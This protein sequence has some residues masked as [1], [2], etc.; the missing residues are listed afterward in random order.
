MSPGISGKETLIIEAP[1]SP[2]KTHPYRMK[3][4]I[5]LVNQK[6]GGTPPFNNFDFQCIKKVY[7]IRRCF[8]YTIKKA[9]H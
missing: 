7:N 4:V 3:H 1:R 8:S 6:L 5:A 2:D 9:G